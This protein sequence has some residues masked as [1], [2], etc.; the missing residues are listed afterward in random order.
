MADSDRRNTIARRGFERVS[1][2]HTYDRRFHELLGG[3]SQQV[4]QRPHQAIDW[5]E[6]ET[7]ARRHRFGPSLKLL[8]A[9][10][11]V[12]ASLLWRKQRGARAARRIVFELSWRLVGLRTYTAAGWPGRMFYKES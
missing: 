10:I 5:P 2:D 6:F 9:A 8:R 1:R 4:A 11:V 7:V 3:L 12:C